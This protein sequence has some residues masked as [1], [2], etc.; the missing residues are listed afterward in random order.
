MT[1]HDFNRMIEKFEVD[2]LEM[3]A[4]Q[5]YIAL[6]HLTGDRHR[7]TGKVYNITELM[8]ILEQLSDSY[9][10]LALCRAICNMLYIYAE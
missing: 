5:R 4:D 6:V 2:M 1:E 8:V 9:I 3:P 10:H 7:L